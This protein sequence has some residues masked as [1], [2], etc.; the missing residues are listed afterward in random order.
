MRK[1]NLFMINKFINFLLQCIE[2]MSSVGASKSRIE[3]RE[4]YLVD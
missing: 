3:L 4:E 2:E 1:K